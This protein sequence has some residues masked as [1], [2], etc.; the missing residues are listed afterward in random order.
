VRVPKIN[1]YL[2][3]ALAERVRSAHL[4][5]SRICQMALSAALGNLD[6]RVAIGDVHELPEALNLEL[7]LNNYAIAFVKNGYASARRRGSDLVESADLLHG[8][9]EEPDS[10]VYRVVE[11]AAGLS[12]AQIRTMLDKRMPR[13]AFDG[14]DPRLS[15]A[16]RTVLRMAQDEAVRTGSPIIHGNHMVMGLLRDQDGVAGALL[17]ELGIDHL[18]NPTVLEL[19]EEGIIYSRSLRTSVPDGWTASM[20]TDLAA[21]LERMEKMLGER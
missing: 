19:I 18:V 8:L 10:F 20:L 17:D 9:L 12:A 14:T 6:H 11:R 13:G 5:V 21:R 7:P 4:P 15:D 3:D 1:V 16:A 2:P